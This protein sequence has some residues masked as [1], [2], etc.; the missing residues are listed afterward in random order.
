MS[1]KIIIKIAVGLVIAVGVFFYVR[2][3]IKLY[4][5]VI[6]QSRRVDILED[7]LVKNFPNQANAYIEAQKLPTNEPLKK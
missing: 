6:L 7:F 1:K 3:E 4:N 2:Y 5:T